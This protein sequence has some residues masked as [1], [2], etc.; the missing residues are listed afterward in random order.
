MEKVVPVRTA[1]EEDGRRKLGVE[2]FGRG[3]ERALDP[4]WV[5]ARRS[6]SSRAEKR[7]GA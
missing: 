7:P 2:D 1:D 3:G 4:Q 5:R 6:V